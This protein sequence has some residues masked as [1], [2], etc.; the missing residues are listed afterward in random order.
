[1]LQ[2]IWQLVVTS[3]MRGQTGYYQGPPPAWV[4]SNMPQYVAMVLTL[5]AMIFAV[6]WVSRKKR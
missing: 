5:A 3:Y 1:V 4:T 2:A 6:R